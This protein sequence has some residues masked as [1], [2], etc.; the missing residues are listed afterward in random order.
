VKSARFQDEL[1]RGR[2]HLK[3]SLG[4]AIE[5][6]QIQ[7]AR[8]QEVFFTGYYKGLASAKSRS[9]AL[10]QMLSEEEDRAQV[11]E[12]VPLGAVGLLV[13]VSGLAGC[14]V[15]MTL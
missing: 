5:E 10:A 6:G 15:G 1:A 4:E 3:E 8:D 11:V 2:E 13:L 9:W 12:G 14:F 7:S